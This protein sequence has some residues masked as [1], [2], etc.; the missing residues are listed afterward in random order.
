MTEEKARLPESLEKAHQPRRLSLSALVWIVLWTVLLFT[1][2][3]YSPKLQSVIV[4]GTA[5]S[6][7][8]S[9]SS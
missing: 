8:W 5:T 2:F 4:R 9:T 1:A 7:P 3:L 6:Y